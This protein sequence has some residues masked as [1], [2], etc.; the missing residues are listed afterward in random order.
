M[1]GWPWPSSLMHINCQDAV[2]LIYYLTDTSE[3]LIWNE[4]V[5]HSA[6]ATLDNRVIQT[7]DDSLRAAFLNQIV[8][9]VSSS[10]D[11][12]A[13]DATLCLT[14]IGAKIQEKKTLKPQILLN[15]DCLWWIKV[16]H[17]LLADDEET[18]ILLTINSNL[19]STETE[20]ASH[21]NTYMVSVRGSIEALDRVKLLIVRSKKSIAIYKI[22]PEHLML[23]STFVNLQNFLQ[24]NS[25]HKSELLLNV[26]VNVEP[27]QSDHKSN[28]KKADLVLR[29][30]KALIKELHIDQVPS[31]TRKINWPYVL[32]S[33]FNRTFWLKCFSLT[34]W[35]ELLLGLAYNYFL[36]T[37]FENL[38]E[39]I[40]VYLT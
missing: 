19:L 31:Q 28:H 22:S 40:I 36:L 35:T 12:I 20:F 18:D 27:P 39:S 9:P 4:V 37:C 33:A 11:I 26:T 5:S 7:L 3:E 30:W 1:S 38:A 24:S 34:F 8:R 13:C 17:T 16:D 14:E 6:R 29:S 21:L 2:T 23:S 32:L 25:L 10:I 15:R